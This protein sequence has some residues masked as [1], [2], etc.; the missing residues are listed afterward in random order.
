MENKKRV[1]IALWRA[2]VPLKRIRQQT[3]ISERTLRQI[4]AKVRGGKW[5]LDFHAARLTTTSRS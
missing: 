4:L 3:K 5:G 2:M 1:A